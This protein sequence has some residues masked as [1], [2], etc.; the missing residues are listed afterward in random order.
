MDRPRLLGAALVRED[1]EAQSP[2]PRSLREI[3]LWKI[4]RHDPHWFPMV[5]FGIVL[6]AFSLLVWITGRMPGGRGRPARPVDPEEA[7]AFLS[8]AALLMASLC[9]IAGLRAWRIRGLFEVGDVVQATVERVTYAKGTSRVRF[10]YEH[11]GTRCSLRRSI[12][13]SARARALKPGD[14]LAIL[15][16]P[17]RPRRVVLAEL[18]DRG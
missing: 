11:R 12:R 14:S 1:R 17:D 2:D 7:R 6:F 15:V 13:K 9:A 10:D 8:V 4:L 16:D 5:A 18:Y 3:T